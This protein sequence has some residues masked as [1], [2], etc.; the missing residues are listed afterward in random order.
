MNQGSCL[1]L[2]LEGSQLFIVETLS[3]RRLVDQQQWLQVDISRINLL[4]IPRCAIGVRL[5]RKTSRAS[6]HLLTCDDGQRRDPNRVD[7]EP[8][9]RLYKG[10]SDRVKTR[11]GFR[12]WSRYSRTTSLRTSRE[13]NLGEERGSPVVQFER[14]H[15][16]LRDSANVRRYPC[17][18]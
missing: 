11:E 13:S 1:G 4:S 14:Y 10:R 9:V 3:K 15:F 18:E 12:R 17:V 5:N 6:V 16:I 8:A 2:W 7:L